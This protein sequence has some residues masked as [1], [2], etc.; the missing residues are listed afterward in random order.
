MHLKNSLMRRKT[1]EPRCSSA[2]HL[3]RPRTQGSG[4][5]RQGTIRIARGLLG[6][7]DS[8]AP[9]ARRHQM[10]PAPGDR[11][12]SRPPAI[13]VSLV[14]SAVLS[15]PGDKWARKLA[16][17]R[18]G[19]RVALIKCILNSSSCGSIRITLVRHIKE[20]FGQPDL[21]GHCQK[22]WPRSHGRGHFIRNS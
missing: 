17:A 2:A 14:W 11:P 22:T 5:S 20:V 8:A 21:A 19:T 6:S 18:L 10:R 4:D 16:R 7:F 15:W 9:T 3:I 13:G 12:W 1:V